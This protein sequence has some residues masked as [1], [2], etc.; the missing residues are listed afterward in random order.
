MGRFARILNVDTHPATRW[1]L[2]S[3]MR[4]C[5]HG[6]IEAHTGEQALELARDCPDAI[7]V[8]V[9]VCAHMGTCLGGLLGEAPELRGVPVLHLTH[10]G[11]CPARV[12]PP[13][14][15]V[16]FLRWPAPVAEFCRALQSMLT[17]VPGIRAGG[18]AGLVTDFFTG[19][20]TPALCQLDTDGRV[21]Q[22]SAG[23]QE[24][25]GWPPHEA[26]NREFPP[27]APGQR[28]TFFTLLND[29]L[30]GQWLPG[31]EM[32]CHNQD[33]T[34]R[35]I[36]LAMAPVLDVAGARGVPRGVQLVAFDVQAQ[37]DMERSL[38]RA[39][40]TLTVLS[41]CNAALV[42]QRDEDGL[43]SR[44][45]AL[46]TDV[47]GYRFSMISVLRDDEGK[48]IEPVAWSGF[49]SD[50]SASFRLSW[51]PDSRFSIG[52]SGQ[53]A[54]TGQVVVVRDLP[55]SVAASVGEWRSF[56]ES[57]GLRAQIVLPLRHSG[58]TYG[59]LGI[60]ATEPDLFDD[61]EVRLLRELADN[62]AFHVHTQR[63]E[64]ARLAAEQ[65][66]RLFGR[67]IESSIN[68]V[69]IT[70]ALAPTHPIVYVNA[71]MEAITGY[72][73]HEVIGGNGR[74][75]VG[76]EVDQ[77]ALERIRIAL[78]RRAP[79]HA[80][81][82][83]RRKDATPFWNELF[84]APVADESGVVTHFISIFN[85]VTERVRR[86]QE[87][88]HLATRD[89]LTGLANRTLLA[90]RLEF[91]IARAQ[92]DHTVVGVLLVDLDQFKNVNDNLGHALGDMLLKAVALRLEDC[93]R[94]GDT[95]ARMGGDEFV[96]V[97]SGLEHPD[98]ATGV[99][100]K[101]M[102][103][104]EQPLRI[105]D[106]ELFVTASIGISLYPR[107]G[108]DAESL[109]RLAD[110]A[111]YR[112]K[113]SGRNAWCCYS[114]DMN[115]RARNLMD[116]E[117][118]LRGALERDELVLHYQPKADLHT[119]AIVGAEAL[120]RW[121]HPARG[122]VPPT[123][124]IPLAEA[125]GLIVPIG[126]WVLREACRRARLWQRAGRAPIVI[127]VNLS[128]RQ[129]RQPDIVETV[130]R[131]LRDAQLDPRWLELELTETVV[132]HNLDIAADVLKRLKA[133]GVGLAMD[134]FGTGYSSLGYLKRFPF[135][136]L[137][138]DQ[139]F[140]CNITTDP[141]D[142]LIAKAVIAMAHSL[143]LRVVAEGV[144]TEAQFRYLR[145]QNCD[146]MQGY[147]LS[148][149]VAHEQFDDFIVGARGIPHGAEPADHL[150]RTLL[151][152]DDEPDIL[153]ALRRLFRRSGYHILTATSAADA[154]ELLAL[155]DVQVIVSDQRMPVMSGSEFLGRVRALYPDTVRLVLSGYSDMN[156]LMS[157]VNRGA[158]YRFISKPWD[159]EDLRQQI[160]E[161][162]MHY[163]ENKYGRGAAD[164]DEGGS[165]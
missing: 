54:I 95:V 43:F 74:I 17:T 49:A 81:L 97:L 103:A 55:D 56:I 57:E 50:P 93:M 86:E 163:E 80:V 31:V 83:C 16:N 60:Y 89:V 147:F 123:E 110:L 47:G 71:A 131:A 27:L 62:I 7:V 124:F 29:A 32:T 108:H 6:V 68:G 30:S 9:D 133:L 72:A 59:V 138:I 125:S 23:A 113:E 148:R 158:I 143:R 130:T 88:E 121:Q 122:L 77:A 73:A 67:A 69:M 53:A 98:D 12:G 82:R 52:A 137:K 39:N 145:L 106:Q 135:D 87:L 85:D 10:S 114:P 28:E 13:S 101:L 2:S 35:R 126:E 84:L 18:E 120:V 1:I 119:G 128:A 14:S 116:L 152:V 36:G 78:R 75:F 100:H 5:G 4:A 109:L 112:A 51:D 102:T 141:D 115:E 140:V 111:M 142:A 37:K 11:G 33:G 149:P 26:V 134:D 66:L 91:S 21:T 63:N 90:D 96:V 162:F 76:N 42:T 144:E 65:Q 3:A 24:L 48:T 118:S 41:R 25:F 139:S 151:L 156:A 153:T 38:L 20:G 40:R 161:A 104:L 46:L 164:E 136:C 92:R 45:C 117:A 157:A 146:Q 129:L 150:T 154:L 94:D 70:D 165:E 160:R 105:N 79:G 58:T 8:G 64:Q 15:E 22:W 34:A 132:M 159:D 127:A 19:W 44:L 107:D 155:N 99:A 61:Y